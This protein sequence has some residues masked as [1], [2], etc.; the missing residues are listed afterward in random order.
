MSRSIDPPAWI[1]GVLIFMLPLLAVW[2]W[3][4]GQ[5]YD[6][7]LLDFSRPGGS[8][9]DTSW[10][11]EQMPPLSRLGAVRYFTRDNLF[12]YVNGHAE[13]YINAGFKELWVAEYGSKESGSRPQLTVD[14]FHM[15]EPMYAFGMLMNETPANVKT[16]AVGTM[17]FD[18]GQGIHF[19]QGPLLIKMTAFVP[20]LPLETWAGPLA[21]RLRE[22]TGKTDL[23][24]G[25]PALG[26]VVETRFIKENYHGLAFF[27]NVLERTFK[28]GDTI[29][30]SFLLSGSPS[31]MAQRKQ[32]LLDFLTRD[33]IPYTLVQEKPIPHLVVHDPYEGDWFMVEHGT[34]FLGIFGMALE[35]LE[36][37]LKDFIKP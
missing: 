3:I 20:N 23:V 5:T 33:K 27:D 1:R 31:E 9:A 35:P 2:I 19:I 22:K 36:Q 29:F 11:P 16:L 18:Y 32:A 13:S 7:G 21:G 14:I 37:P 28:R 8:A 26:E 34:Q 30:Q 6:P 17:G 4:D 24:I 15:G 10:I 25:F 12:E